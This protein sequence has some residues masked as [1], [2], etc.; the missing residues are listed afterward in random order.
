M[1]K[2]ILIQQKFLVSI[3]DTGG[4][5]L[6]VFLRAYVYKKVNENCMLCGV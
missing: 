5:F 1:K 2:I 6:L 4:A 3:A